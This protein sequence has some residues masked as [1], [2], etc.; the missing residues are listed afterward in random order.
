MALRF[1]NLK[2]ETG[3]TPPAQIKIDA[4]FELPV[5]DRPWPGIYI[6]VFGVHYKSRVLAR[7]IGYVFRR[8]GS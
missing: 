1:L 5:A 4:G 8:F 6:Q 3:G 2:T 7:L